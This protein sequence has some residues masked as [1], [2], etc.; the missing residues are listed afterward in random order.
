MKHSIAI[1]GLYL[2][3]TIGLSAQTALQQLLQNPALKHASVGIQVT[4]LKSGRT[5]ASHD[6]E[7]SLTPA[8]VT[9]LITTAGAL[10][11]LGSDYRYE[12]K[13][14]ID[15]TD[16]SRILV[17]GAGDPTLG[18]EALGDNPHHFFEEAARALSLQL[19][20]TDT[21]T[22]YV[23]DD[24]F[25]YE[26][27]SPE[28]TWI[29]L[30]NYYASAAYGVSVFDNSYKL[31]FN[32]LDQSKGVQ[33]VRTEP[34]IRQ[35]SIVNE[36]TLNST[37]RD[38]GYLYGAPF[39]YDRVVRGNIPA[40]RRAFSIKGDIP[41]PAQLLGETLADYLSR[42]N[43]KV[44][45]VTTAR[46]DYLKGE[47][48][49]YA[50]G[51]AVYAH[52]SPTL[53]DI[54][55]ETNVVS[56]NHYAE[57]LIRTIGVNNRVGSHPD[58]LSKG[59]ETLD[60]LWKQKGIATTSVSLH[61]GSGLA[62]QNAFS[63]AFLTELL[64]YMYNRSG[65]SSAFVQ[66]LPT[67]GRDGTL[68]NFMRNTRYEGKI[69]AKSGSIGGVHCYSGYLIDGDKEYSFTIMVNKFNGTRPQ[70]RSAIEKYLNSL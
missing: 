28:W 52:L 63:A 55:R 49:R 29:D 68:R 46:Q 51:T 66:S 19:S 27:V 6:A 30:G 32:T 56:N 7:R 21:Y 65:E 23:V 47:R 34:V 31:F 38:N 45:T 42:Y 62:P 44:S 2:L 1:L 58:A 15:A 9:K 3:A 54:S 67:A 70:V 36:L 18:S 12:T 39:S 24:L 57:H 4:D 14:A 16:P 41:D 25:G 10:E 37:G 61:D 33:V 48:P 17:V 13:V 8:S 50:I 11:L 35:L 60:K 26:G 53:S 40:G 64:Y 22:I 43:L 20:T 59:I 5:V 69:K